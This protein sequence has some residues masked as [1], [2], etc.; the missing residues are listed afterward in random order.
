MQFAESDIID[1]AHSVWA[2]ILKLEADVDQTSSFLDRQR[3]LT[4]QVHISGQWT[5]TVVL[6]CSLHLAQKAASIMFDLPVESLEALDIQDALAELANMI[7][8]NLK[9]IVPS[10]SFLS[11]PCV[12]EGD[13]YSLRYPKAMPKI[14]LGFTCSEGRF[15]ILVLEA[16]S[17]NEAT[18]ALRAANGQ[19]LE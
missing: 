11:L 10:P 9:S 15:A 17:E 12:T 18:L 2:S 16:P 6:S 13:D 7:G 4:A 19:S 8:G 3:R 1:I 5:G 14:Q